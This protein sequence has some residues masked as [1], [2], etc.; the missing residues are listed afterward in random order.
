MRLQLQLSHR[1]PPTGELSSAD[2]TTVPFAGRLELL[3]ALE[4][5]TSTRNAAFACSA[6]DPID[7]QH[8]D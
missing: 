5:F 2:G 3:A 6:S 4:S 1:D 7:R 8:A